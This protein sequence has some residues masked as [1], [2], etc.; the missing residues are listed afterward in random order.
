VITE[1]CCGKKV[2]KCFSGPIHFNG[3]TGINGIGRQQKQIIKVVVKERLIN[4]LQ[5]DTFGI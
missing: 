5:F 1:S 4:A 3:A 2:S